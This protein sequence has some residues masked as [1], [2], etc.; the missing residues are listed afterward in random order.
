MQECLDSVNNANCGYRIDR[1]K[2]RYISFIFELFNTTNYTTF[3]FRTWLI[4]LIVNNKL[5][6]VFDVHAFQHGIEIIF[7]SCKCT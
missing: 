1:A 7:Y 4:L 2:K 3:Y 6:V 5:K